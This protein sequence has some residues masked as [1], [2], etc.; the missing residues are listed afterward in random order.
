MST[1]I[2]AVRVFELDGHEHPL[3]S[4]SGGGF[5]NLYSYQKERNV[6]S[7]LYKLPTPL[8]TIGNLDGKQGYLISLRKNSVVDNDG[9][10]TYYLN[11]AR[12]EINRGRVLLKDKIEYSKPFP[13]KKLEAF[14]LDNDKRDE[15]ICEIGG[16]DFGGGIVILKL[17]GDK[18]TKVLNSGVN[19]YKDSQFMGMWGADVGPAAKLI[20]YTTDPSKKDDVNTKFGLLIISFDGSRIIHERFYPLN[21]MLDDINNTRKV[22]PYSNEPDHL[23]LVIVDFDQDVNQYTLKAPL[24]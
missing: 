12:L 18:I 4:I 10:Q 8:V 6:L 22:L 1:K 7:L 15:I 23:P 9:T 19:T 11:V 3:V 2:D 16:N 17:S 20:L 5:T 21:P 24:L 14:D 13:I